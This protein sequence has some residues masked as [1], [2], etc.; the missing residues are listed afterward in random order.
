MPAPYPMITA[1]CGV[2]PAPVGVVASGPGAVAAQGATGQ[3]AGQ[4]AFVH[5][6]DDAGQVGV[7]GQQPTAAVKSLSRS[8]VIVCDAG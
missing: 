5:A 8:V 3:V 4:R 1:G 7:G 6:A 2:A